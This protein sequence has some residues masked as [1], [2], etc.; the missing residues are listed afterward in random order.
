MRTI[1]MACTIRYPAMNR[2]Y[3]NY[4]SRD[5]A[6]IA[7]D[8]KQVSGANMNPEQCRGLPANNEIATP[9]FVGWD[10]E[11]LGVHGV[12]RRDGCGTIYFCEFHYFC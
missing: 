4:L 2:G 6:G 10:S 12:Y 1:R 9:H 11:K 5:P 7:L 8:G 3:V